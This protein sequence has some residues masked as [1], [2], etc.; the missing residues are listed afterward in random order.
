M[1]VSNGV[2]MSTSHQQGWVSWAFSALLFCSTATLGWFYYDISAKHGALEN[3]LTRA[4]STLKANERQSAQ[5]NQQLVELRNELSNTRIQF[6][7]ISD[8]LETAQQQQ[9]EYETTLASLTNTQNQLKQATQNVERLTDELSAKNEELAS[10][11]DELSASQENINTLQGALNEAAT[12]EELYLSAREQ[13]ALQQ[14]E[15]ES[16]SETIE[17]LKAEMADEANAMDAL[18]KSLQ[19]QLTEINQEKEKLVTQLEDGT[20]AIR[21]P[22]S[23]LFASGSAELNGDGVKALEVLSDALTSFPNHLISIQGHTDS[24]KIASTV[25]KK[26]PTN[27]ELSTAR[28]S[29]AVRTLIDQGLPAQQIQAVGFA[30]TRPLVEEVDAASRQQNRRIEVLLLPNQFKT[31]VLE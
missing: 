17:R 14:A 12:T 19:A 27:W 15:N 4:Q 5:Q 10:K 1:N 3:D 11:T 28:A 21:L 9:S 29:S 7:E 22:E 25:A 8:E 31:K 16:Y 6:A 24:K 20:T 2:N 18:E 26:F 23:I 30:D 13:L